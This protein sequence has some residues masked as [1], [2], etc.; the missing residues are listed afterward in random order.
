MDKKSAKEY[1]CPMRCEGDKVYQKPGECPI[2]NMQLVLVNKKGKSSEYQHMAV[3]SGHDHK[4][5]KKK[6]SI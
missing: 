6:T 4:A 2:C 3:Q 1:A 5:E